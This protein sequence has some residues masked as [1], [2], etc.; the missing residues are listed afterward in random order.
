MH[1]NGIRFIGKLNLTICI[2]LILLNDYKK[3]RLFH[4]MLP[5][6]YTPCLK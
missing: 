3:N 1:Y 2:N 6:Y 4:S 5:Y